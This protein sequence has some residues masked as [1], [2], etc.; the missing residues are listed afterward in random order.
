[1]SDEDDGADKE[2]ESLEDLDVGGTG[3]GV[4]ELFRE[5]G[6]VSF[7]RGAGEVGGVGADLG[8]D[9]VAERR[10]LALDL[11]S[12]CTR[13]M[14]SVFPLGRARSGSHFLRESWGVVVVQG[15]GRRSRSP[16]VDFDLT[17]LASPRQP[18]LASTSF[19]PSS[20]T[21]TRTRRL[22]LDLCLRTRALG[23]P[24]ELLSSPPSL[25]PTPKVRVEVDPASP[26]PI[27]HDQKVSLASSWVYSFKAR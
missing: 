24:P 5:R 17:R 1:M 27:H 11:G 19:T 18:G 12:H 2:A 10:P 22:G 4:R 21:P 20:C 9:Y 26:H 16:R 25:C 8:A 6:R 13:M 15:K 7:R 14:S 3:L 23:P